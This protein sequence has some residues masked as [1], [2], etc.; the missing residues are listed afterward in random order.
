MGWTVK[1]SKFN[2]G[3]VLVL[4]RKEESVA[5][6]RYVSIT[7]NTE[8]EKL[9]ITNEGFRGMGIKNGLRY[10]FSVMYRQ[11]AP[12]LTLHIELV[13]P[14]GKIIG[15][16]VLAPTGSKG[17]AKQSVSFNATDTASKA[18]MNIWFEG[19]GKIDLDS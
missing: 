5:N 10:D 11:Q 9:S 2:E 13:S 19:A 3:S 17:W 15:S 8:A 6:P 7:K 18:K 4:N 14:A 16:A 12:A 1:Q